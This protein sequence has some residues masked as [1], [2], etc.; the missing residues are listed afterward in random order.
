MKPILVT[1][2]AIV[3]LIVAVPIANTAA[4]H[5]HAI[6]L[7]QIKTVAFQKAEAQAE[8][9][10]VE[11]AKKLAA[12]RVAAEQKAAADAAAKQA[13]LIA[14][15]GDCSLY[16]S[17]VAQYNWNVDTA[18]AVM[19]AENRT[20][21]PKINN[22]GVN[23]DGSV[24]YGLFQ[25]NSSNSKLFTSTDTLY[26]PAVNIHVAYVLYSTSSRGWGNWSTYNSGKYRQ[27]LQ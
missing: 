13:A 11:L 18:M 14:N 1:L 12:E 22:A 4:D 20:C 3:S 17:M 15:G 23:T 21:L 16:R 24:D 10:K 6:E 9:A 8:Q 26:D 25:I 7:A 19:Q 27:F 5:A 2:A